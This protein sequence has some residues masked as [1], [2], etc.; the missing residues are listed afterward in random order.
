MLGVVP[1]SAR[2]GGSRRSCVR[3]AAGRTA[4]STSGRHEDDG[5]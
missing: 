2:L 3:A 1:V 4:E 5:V